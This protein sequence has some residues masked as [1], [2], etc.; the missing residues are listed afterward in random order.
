MNNIF[1]SLHLIPLSPVLNNNVRLGVVC[2]CACARAGWLN[3]LMFFIPSLSAY[4]VQITRLGAGTI[5]MKKI[6]SSAPRCLLP[7]GEM[8]PDTYESSVVKAM[9]AL[10]AWVCGWGWWQRGGW[11]QSREREMV[12]GGEDHWEEVR[13][14]L[15]WRY[16]RV[17]NS[18]SLI[19]FLA[20]R[21]R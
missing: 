17:R 15:S 21:R 9:T 13:P 20:Q 8:E 18:H 11:A 19:W 14:Q 4:C 2:V 3:S 6:E 12:G 1:S 7:N 5:K 16:N 10:R